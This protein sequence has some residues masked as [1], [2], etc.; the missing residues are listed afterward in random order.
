MGG[1]GFVT[2][3]R[4]V[5][6]GADPQVPPAAGAVF[7]LGAPVT[8]TALSWWESRRLRRHHGLSI[9]NALGR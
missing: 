7:I 3:R 4:I 6:T 8:V 2:V 1:R 9:R 5:I